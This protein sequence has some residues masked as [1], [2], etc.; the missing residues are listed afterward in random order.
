[1]RCSSPALGR[2]QR[3]GRKGPSGD[4]VEESAFDFFGGRIGFAGSRR[5]K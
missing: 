5:R 1:M 4:G 3:S 2:L